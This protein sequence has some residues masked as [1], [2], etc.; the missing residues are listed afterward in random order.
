MTAVHAL[1]PLPRTARARLRASDVMTAPVVTVSPEATVKEIASLMLA[2]HVSGLPVVSS[3][4]ELVGIVT[5]A[6]L[7]HKERGP[8]RPDGRLTR[9]VRS[10]GRAR[11]VRRKAGG[12]TAADLMSAPVVTVDEAAPLHEIAAVMVR[13]AINRVPVMRGGR[14]VGIVSRADIVRA[15]TRTDAEVADAVRATLLHD[16]WLDVSRLDID[17]QDGVV[18]LEGRVER[19]S[20]RELAARWAAAVDGVVAVDSRLDY[21]YDDRDVHLGDRWPAPRV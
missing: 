10:L 21:E 5:E 4:G 7:L 16:L 11:D 3:A 9:A 14:L 15:L 17:V 6:D 13:R 18:R 8:H 19:R 1:A 20:E 12:L 2:H